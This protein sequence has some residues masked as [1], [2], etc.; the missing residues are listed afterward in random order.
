LVLEANRTGAIIVCHDQQQASHIA[1]TFNVKTMTISKY[2]DGDFHR[3][4]RI[5]SRK[6]LFDSV[7]QV[8]LIQKKLSEATAI[9]KKDFIGLDRL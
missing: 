8:K 6:F 5:G 9:M 4:V 7:T 3:G 2:L 1:R